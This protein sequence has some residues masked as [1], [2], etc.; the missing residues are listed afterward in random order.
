MSG[1]WQLATRGLALACSLLGAERASANPADTYGLGSRS[2]ALGGAVSANAKDA[3]ANY[4][5]PARLALAEAPEVNLGFVYVHPSFQLG[6]TDSPASKLRSLQFGLVAPGAVLDLPVAFGLATQMAEDRLSRVITFTEDDQRWFLYDNRPEQIYL[7][8]NLALS[9]LSWLS[10]GAG[11]SFLASTSGVLQIRGTAVQPGFGDATE[12][13]SDLQHQVIAELES[14]RYPQVGLSIHPDPLLHAALVYRGE[15]QVA[16]GVDSDIRGDLALATLR[17]P[18][19]YILKSQTIQSFVPRQVVLGLSS[20]PIDELLL[21][22]DLA[23]VNWASFPSPISATDSSIKID[24]PPG[25]NVDTPEL[26]APTQLENAQL[27]NRFNLRF[28][29]ESR[30]ALTTNLSLPVRAGYSYEPTGLS[31]DSNLNLLDSDRHTAS[32]GT[33]VHWTQPSRVFPGELRLDLHA[34]TA[35]FAERRFEPPSGNG[36]AQLAS[37]N[38]IGAGVNLTYAFSR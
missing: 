23:W 25:L 36:E 26:P 31:Q 1:R 11:L 2:T 29:A 4:Y 5:N 10:L 28:G 33:G 8:A 22:L 3:S 12:Y 38:F 18:T 24:T 14:V 32:V 37:G 6:E 9:P 27:V 13:D 19:E 17:F 20:T 15:G 34:Q 16:L 35:F 7:S 21:G 30:I